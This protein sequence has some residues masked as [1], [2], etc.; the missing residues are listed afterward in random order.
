MCH[1]EVNQARLFTTADDLD[2]VTERLLSRA[3]K[4]TAVANLPHGVGAHRAY[5]VV[6]KGAQ[7][8]T[9][10]R[11]AVEGTCLSLCAEALVR[12]ETAPEANRVAQAVEYGQLFALTHCHDHVETVGAEVDGGYG[13]EG[14]WN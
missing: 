14:I 11:Q 10:A 5:C 2:R 7:A 13:V 12:L 6:W 1:T 3:Q 9:H 4:G 8:L